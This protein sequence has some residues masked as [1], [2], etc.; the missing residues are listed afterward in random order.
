VTSRRTGRFLGEAYR[1]H[2]LH[3]QGDLWVLSTEGG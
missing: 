2:V 1:M 3:S